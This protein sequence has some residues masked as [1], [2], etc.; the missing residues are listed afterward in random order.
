MFLL[1]PTVGPLLPPCQVCRALL[2]V[3]DLE[4][5]STSPGAQILSPTPL[6]PYMHRYNNTT[7]HA[8]SEPTSFSAHMDS[9]PPPNSRLA[10]SYPAAAAAAALAATPAATPTATL[11]ATPTATP[12]PTP[13]ATPATPQHQ[14]QIRTFFVSFT[15][16]GLATAY[17]D[18]QT[19]LRVYTKPRAFI[20]VPGH[21]LPS[22]HGAP[23]SMIDIDRTK[24]K[25]IAS[26][27]GASNIARSFGLGS[28]GTDSTT[29]RDYATKVPPI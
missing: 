19:D 18:R 15:T 6:H 1:R 17:T 28:A 8:T 5:A 26:S 12:T 21:P 9:F 3:A 11:A 13:A 27:N 20:I 29:G 7:S 16:R 24:G 22:P 4:M 23:Y 25:H 2:S 10:R 14:P